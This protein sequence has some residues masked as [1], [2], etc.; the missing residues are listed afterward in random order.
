M[1][2]DRTPEARNPPV[3]PETVRDTNHGGGKYS[4]EETRALPADG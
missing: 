3:L 2:P 1:R 4:F